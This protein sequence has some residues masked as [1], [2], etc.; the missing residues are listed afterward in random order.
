MY[1]IYYF[2][3]VALYTFRYSICVHYGQKVHH[4]VTIC[5]INGSLVINMKLDRIKQVCMFENY[6]GMGFLGIGI[7]IR[8]VIS[9]S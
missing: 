5:L 2:V 6:I 8:I 7:T 4:T 9:M 1:N 3:S